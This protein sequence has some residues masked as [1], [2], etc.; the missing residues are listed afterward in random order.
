MRL[1]PTII[2]F[3]TAYAT[4]FKCS[5]RRIVDYPNLHG[6]LRDV[7]QIEFPNQSLQIKDT[8]DA[9]DARRSYSELFPLNPGGIVPSGPTTEDLNLG[10]PVDRGSH[11]INDVFIMKEAAVEA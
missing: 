10:K 5:K 11:H 2:R 4:L 7:Y 9:D 8:F 6:W 1:Y 3:D